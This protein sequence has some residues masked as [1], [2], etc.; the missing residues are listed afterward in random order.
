M[1]DTNTQN[2]RNWLKE[3][4][5]RLPKQAPLGEG[6]TREPFFNRELIIGLVLIFALFFGLGRVL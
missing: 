6:E 5:E 3:F 2:R 1:N 4:Q